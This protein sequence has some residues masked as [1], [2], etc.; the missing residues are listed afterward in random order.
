MVEEL[1]IISQAAAHPPNSGS[2]EAVLPLEW[3]D[4]YLPPELIAQEPLPER[5]QARLL[6]VNRQSGTWEHRYV[7]ELPD[8]LR[9][10]DL[11]VLNNT[12]VFPARLR[13]TK[14]ITIAPEYQSSSN[15]ADEVIIIRPGTDPALALGLAHVIIKE[16]RYAADYV[17]NFTDL[18]L[19]VRM[20]TLKLL[21][22]ADITPDYTPA[23]LS[24]YARVLAPGERPDPGYNQPVQYISQALR[25]KWGDYV[26]W[27]T[28]TNAPAVITRD[29]VGDHFAKL[30]IEPALEG[31]VAVTTTAGEQIKVRPFFDILREYLEEFNP[32]NVSAITWAPVE[33]I[34]S[35][36]RQIA[37]HPAATLIAHGMGPNH[38][39]NADLKD[40]TLFL[41]AALK[42]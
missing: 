37:D 16:R 18:P 6:V 33:A 4:Y 36:A 23:P 39:F 35:L 5:D 40:R 29:H 13:G 30:G 41:V 24:N 2:A 9:P 17:K 8:I 26:V 42:K 32:Q 25:D 20:D 7:Y 21:N 10:G 19:L 38:F 28:K 1:Q 3:F 11:V 34:E 12:K 22:A 14:V 31:E 15:K 27:D